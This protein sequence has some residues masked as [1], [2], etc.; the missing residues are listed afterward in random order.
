MILRYP[1]KTP[2]PLKIFCL[3]LGGHIAIPFITQEFL[4]L[5]RNLLAKIKNSSQ[6]KNSAE[7]YWVGQFN[8]VARNINPILTAYE[9]CLTRQPTKEEFSA[10]LSASRDALLKIYPTKNIVQHTTE[11]S[12]AL[13]ESLTR[14][15]VSYTHLDVYKRQAQT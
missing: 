5:D 13:V 9:G 3:T 15:P 7:I 2:H 11:F 6:L 12:A 8:Q 10:E 4:L 14:K 1:F